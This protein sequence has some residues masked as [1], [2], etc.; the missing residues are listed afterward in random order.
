MWMKSHNIAS[1]ALKHGSEPPDSGGADICR[2]KKSLE[3][4]K[5]SFLDPEKQSESPVKMFSFSFSG[6]AVLPGLCA[7][8]AGSR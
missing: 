5:I 1:S 8:A 6:S 7:V 4:D 3:D 2:D